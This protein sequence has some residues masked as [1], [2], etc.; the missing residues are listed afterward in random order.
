MQAHVTYMYAGD[1]TLAPPVRLEDPDGVQGPQIHQEGEDLPGGDA[2]HAEGRDGEDGGATAPELV[3][4]GDP[5]EVVEDGDFIFAV[6]PLDEAGLG[7]GAS[8]GVELVEGHFS[9]APRGDEEEGEGRDGAGD[10]AHGDDIVYLTIYRGWEGEKNRR[11]ERE[12]KKEARMV[13]V[14]RS[15]Q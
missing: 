9:E 2:V 1:Q 12:G 4:K 11:A 7:R 6:A 3:E 14:V 8:G 10:D 13:G 5:V 15:V